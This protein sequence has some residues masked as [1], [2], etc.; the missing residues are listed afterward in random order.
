ME[1]LK[2]RDLLG[3]CDLT[4]EEINF[5]LNIARRLKEDLKTGNIFVNGA[6]L[7]AGKR[8]RIK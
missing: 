1:K 3:I 6:E 2:G 7:T 4:G 8:L 5:I